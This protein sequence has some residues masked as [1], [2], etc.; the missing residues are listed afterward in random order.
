MSLRNSL[1]PCGSKKKFKKCCLLKIREQEAYE[2]EYEK[3]MRL[4]AVPCSCKSGKKFGECCL[5][6]QQQNQRQTELKGE[7]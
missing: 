7:V 5:V 1:C 3:A 6:K 2:R 4:F